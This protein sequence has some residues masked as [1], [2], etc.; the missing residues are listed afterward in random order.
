MERR[1]GWT[2]QLLPACIYSLWN[3]T[4]FPILYLPEDRAEW[5]EDCRTC[6]CPTDNSMPAKGWILPSGDMGS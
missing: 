1:S 3:K 6:V 5:R 2:D 4:L